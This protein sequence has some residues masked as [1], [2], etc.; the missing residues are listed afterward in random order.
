MA[1]GGGPAYSG[2]PFIMGTLR[3]SRSF[4]VTP[5]GHLTGVVF[6]RVWYPGTNHADCRVEIGWEIP[7]RGTADTLTAINTPGP[8]G[9][10]PWRLGWEWAIGTERGFTTA[11]P[12]PI[13]QDFNA[14]GHDIA[15]CNCGFYGFLDG[16]TD[17][18]SDSRAS[19]IVEGFGMVTVGT[20][21]FRA[22]KARIIAL[23]MP[24]EGTPDEDGRVPSWQLQPGATEKVAANYPDI[25]LY[26]DLHRMLFDYPTAP[27]NQAAIEPPR[28]AP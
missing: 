7:G 4:S 1:V 26:T 28:D 12:K 3:G 27:P 10:S 14:D 22:S 2:R 6:R 8:E 13:W 11:K 15:D 19:G 25:P 18:A 5:T 20:R 16:S 23:Y 17:Y 9:G 24:P 21:G